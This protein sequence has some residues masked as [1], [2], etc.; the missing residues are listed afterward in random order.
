MNTSGYKPQAGSIPWKVI[1]FL[2]THPDESLSAADVEIKFGKARAQVHSVLGP[3][4]MSGVLIRTEDLEEGELQYKLGT[5]HPEVKANAVSHPTLKL[6][7]PWVGPA[8]RGVKRRERLVLD[9][10][11]LAKSIR[12]GVPL[13]PIDTRRRS[14]NWHAL[15]AHLE[16]G[17]SV[18]LP[19]AAKSTLLKAL[20]A[21]YKDHAGVEFATRIVDADQIGLWRVK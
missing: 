17:D 13:P 1:E 5:G 10:D 6:T 21:Y 20:T 19:N 4:V 11:V 9:T 16:P 2:T 15:L 18:V 3:A 8:T 14:T 7:E 12:K